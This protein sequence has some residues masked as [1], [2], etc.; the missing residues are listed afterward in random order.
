MRYGLTLAIGVLVA[1]V[2]RA[3]DYPKTVLKNDRLALTVYLPDAQKGFYRGTRFDWAGVLGQVEVAGHK[4]FGPWKETHD[5]AN[6]D[7]IVGPV[8]EFGMAAPLGYAEAK[9]GETF[10][11]IGVG[12]LVKPKEEAYRFY[13]NYP[14]LRPG[15][16]DVNVRAGEVEFKQSMR[17]KSGYGYRYTK[18]VV[19]D[20]SEAGFSIRHELTNVGTRP[21]DTD[22]YNHNFYNVDNDPVGPNYRVRFPAPV[23]VPEPK[24]RFGELVAVRDDSFAFTGALDKGSVFT[25]VEGLASAG[26]PGP[27]RIVHAGSKLVLT[28]QGDTPLEKV[29]FWATTRTLC[30][31]PFIRIRLQP[32][33]TKRWSVRYAFGVLGS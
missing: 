9:E 33:E 16:W 25:G 6:H 2:G 3:D 18:R 5:P 23:R 28:F 10:L 15:T 30:P 26:P 11:K 24:E 21:I 4:V 13:Y 1:G 17:S 32:G 31:E 14:I 20:P 29:N 7:D 8:E 12:E 22:H 27:F 19:L